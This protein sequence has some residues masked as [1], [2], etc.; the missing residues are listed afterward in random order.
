[1]L[2]LHHSPLACSLASRLA[3]VEAGLPHDVAFVRTWLGEQKTEQYRAINPR[4]KV[5]ALKTPE[6]VVTESTAILPYIA[7]LAPDKRLFPSPGTFER[8][9]AQSWLS[10]LSSTLH[11]S[12]NSAM[13][14]PPG[15]DNDVAREAAIGRL[16][17][18]FADIEAHLE[19]RD[20]LLDAFSVCDLY[21]MVFATWRAAPAIAGRLPALPNVDRFQ[22]VM[23]ARPGIMQIVME[24]GKMRAAG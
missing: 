14:S 8:A 3:L 13:F 16:A 22:Q 5:P 1:M 24:E 11:A 12:F 6:G 10:F 4:G 2:T 19:G 9:Q 18:A 20:F 23:F 17:A 21:L 7:D 15:C